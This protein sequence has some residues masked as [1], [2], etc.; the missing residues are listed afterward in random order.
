MTKIYFAIIA[1]AIFTG[2]K[3]A[4]KAYQKGNYADAIELGI[5]KLQKD[6]YDYETRDIVKNSY[7]YA[8]SNY[9]N[10]IRIL[11]NSKSEERYARIFYQYLNLQD[12]YNIL[13][14]YPVAFNIVKPADYSEYVETYRE[15]SIEIHVNR[16][17]YFIS[18][19]SKT[20]FREAYYE[21]N[22]ALKFTSDYNLKRKRDS[23]YD[24]A[25]TKVLIVPIQ[26]YGGYQYSSSYQL[27]NF[28]NDILR[29]LSQNSNNDFVRYYSEFEARSRDIIPDQVMEL[30]L[31]RIM[32]GRPYDRRSSRE[33]SKEVVVKEIVHKPDSVTKQY[34]TVKARISTITR[35]LLSEGDLLITLRDINGGIIWSDRFTGQF[36]WRTE[37][38]TYTGDERALSQNDI[39]L[40]N[41]S[42]DH[43][44]SE[45]YILEHL[46]RQIQNDLASRLRTYYGRY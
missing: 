9:E 29:T 42:E 28:Q 25:L 24:L 22:K 8:V 27:Q 34:G 12:L 37:F 35:T 36:Q 23:V 13:N 41:K 14:D 2:C 44:P 39:N 40:I 26:Y 4:S 10:E 11:S 20:D 15:K 45:E 17:D 1:F 31:N 43:L 6:P 21:M 19:G 5:K 33:V 18:L 16:A 3:S 32:M 7:K 30:Q 38:S 46:L